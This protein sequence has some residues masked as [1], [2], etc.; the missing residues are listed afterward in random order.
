[1]EFQ[2]TCGMLIKQLHDAVGRKLN[3]SLRESGLTNVQLGT[4][5]ALEHAVNRR[6]R[7]KDLEKIFQVSQPTIVGIVDRLKEKELVRTLRD[8]QDRR[9]RL[10]ELTEDGLLKARHEH[11]VLVETESDMLGSLSETE[12]RE[13]LRMLRTLRDNFCTHEC[14]PEPSQSSA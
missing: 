6:L 10:V 14:P 5:I 1:M 9:V 8:P 12:Q 3:N 11:D 13:L 4:L 7:M 2:E